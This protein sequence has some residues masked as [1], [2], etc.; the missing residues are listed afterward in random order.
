MCI[1]PRSKGIRPVF[2][3]QMIWRT[4]G[5]Q[6]TAPVKWRQ[7]DGIMGAFWEA[8]S[9]RGASGYYLAEDPRLIV[10]FEDVSAR[11][12]H[13][14]DFEKRP[15]TP[16][17]RATYVPAGMPMWTSSHQSHKFRHLNLHLHMDRLL[18]F[19][20]PALGRSAAQAVLKKPVEAQELGAIDTLVRMLVDEI[21]HPAKHPLFAENLV[22]S[23]LTG[24]LDLDVE[25][26]ARD[27][28]RLTQG[29]M[30]KLVAV[31][32]Q[33]GNARISVAEMA[34]VLGLS[35]SWFGSAFKQ[36]TGKTPAHWLIEHRINQAKELLLEGRLSIADIA[37][38]L[39]FTDQAHLTRAF[40]KID[41]NT[42]A[43]WRKA[44]TGE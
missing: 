23:I 22:G 38:R 10:F 42:P 36:T 9:E 5:I 17:A 43:Q 25:A 29:Q 13:K 28:G 11:I 33:R 3:P 37:A 44:H 21:D 20:T 30:K 16:M 14:Y 1:F 35:E 12:T 41:G 34:E 7:Y 18:K 4:E 32:G 2:F 31:V 27:R 15:D 39:S 8:E 19:I 24:F 6:V 40:R 26:P